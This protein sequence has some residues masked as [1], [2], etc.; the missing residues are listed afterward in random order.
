M[1]IDDVHVINLLAATIAKMIGQMQRR[2]QQ[3]VIM[4][5]AIK[6]G[7][8]QIATAMN[9]IRNTRSGRIRGGI[10]TTIINRLKI[11]HTV[12]DHLVV[13]QE[14]HTQI[15]KMHSITIMNN[16]NLPSIHKMNQMVFE[17]VA[18]EEVVLV[19][20]PV[21]KHLQSSRQHSSYHWVYVH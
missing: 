6:T 5:I 20:H 7:G 18:Q 11:T 19:N 4:I 12:Q 9:I 2:Q 21:I 17:L 10:V 15:M 13:H 16:H 3:V 8:Q 14:Q 1:K